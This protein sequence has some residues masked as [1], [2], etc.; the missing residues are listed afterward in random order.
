MKK[1]GHIAVSGVYS[2]WSAMGGLTPGIIRSYWMLIGKRIFGKLEQIE[3]RYDALRYEKVA[4]A[5][6][7][8][9]PTPAYGDA[10]VVDQS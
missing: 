9:T 5:P 7:V 1:T 6:A 4:D 2:H 10:A 3:N 8:M